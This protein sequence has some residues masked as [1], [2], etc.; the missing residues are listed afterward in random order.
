MWF[1]FFLHYD[2]KCLWLY[3][4][5]TSTEAAGDN[6]KEK[7]Y[8][9]GVVSSGEISEIPLMT[10]YLSA[11]S[12]SFVSLWKC[13]SFPQNYAGNIERSLSHAPLVNPEFGRNPVKSGF[14]CSAV[15]L[16]DRSPDLFGMPETF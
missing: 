9:A 3:S 13:S 16:R 2:V 11:C 8:K 4:E 15:L 1:F 14:Q 10:I 12:K 6:Y 7:S 5:S